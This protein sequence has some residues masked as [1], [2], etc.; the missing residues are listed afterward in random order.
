MSRVE[1]PGRSRWRVKDSILSP[2]RELPE[3]HMSAETWQMRQQGR[4][5]LTEAITEARE[6]HTYDLQRHHMPDQTR[7]SALQPSLGYWLRFPRLGGQYLVRY[8]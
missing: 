2:W 7:I 3:L 5:V 4:F 1:E 8:R 6:R